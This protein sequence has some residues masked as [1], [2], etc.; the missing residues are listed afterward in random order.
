MV[1][2]SVVIEEA[3]AACATKLRD[4]AF[5]AF[6]AVYGGGM[7]ACVGLLLLLTGTMGG[8]QVQ[9]QTPDVNG[10]KS[11]EWFLRPV[12]M[13]TQLLGITAS[14][15]ESAQT[16]VNQV[17]FGRAIVQALAS[18][19]I[20]Y[21]SQ[22][23]A[24]NSTFAP[25]ET[26]TAKWT[27]KNSTTSAVSVDRAV[28]TATVV[29]FAD[30]NSQTVGQTVAA[31]GT[32]TVSI[33]MR[34]PEMPGTY[35]MES[36]RLYG[37]NNAVVFPTF[38]LTIK[39]QPN[40]TPVPIPTTAY[41]DGR[42]LFPLRPPGGAPVGWDRRFAPVTSSRFGDW[43]VD[44]SSKKGHLGEDY[45]INSGTPVYSIGRGTVVFS[46]DA[47]K[48]WGNVVIIAHRDP[49]FPNESR[50]IYSL[51]AHLSS[52]SGAVE[53]G[54]V[55]WN[56]QIGLSGREGTGD[57]LHLELRTG[58]SGILPSTGNGT[59]AAYDPGPGYSNDVVDVFN[60]PSKTLT[61]SGFQITWIQ[62]SS[63]IRQYLVAPK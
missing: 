37:L 16:M 1:N 9:A 12:A 2:L 36:W 41:I 11:T 53:G 47:G 32:F 6:D 30:V 52:R 8:N 60:T 18:G 5:A 62:P 61:R 42:F 40:S 56:T 20:T 49:R 3:V 57:H 55:D 35:Y 28:N 22:T 39:V 10:T 25:G 19:N 21:V 15:N 43:V 26:F 51:Y 45:P 29:R 7:M 31:G 34:A 24:D 59:G 54:L 63:F 17:P 50:A 46:R 23:P 4:T 44:D 33:P 48:G 13:H 58:T 27:F 38:T 14:A